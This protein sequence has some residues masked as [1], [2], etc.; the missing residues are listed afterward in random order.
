MRVVSANH[1]FSN[2]LRILRVGAL[3]VRHSIDKM[4]SMK[5]SYYHYSGLHV[6]SELPLPEWSAFESSVVPTAP[7]DVFNSVRRP[8]RSAARAGGQ[9]AL[10][11]RQRISLLRSPNKFLSR[12]RG[13]RNSCPASAESGR[14]E[15]AVKNNRP[16]ESGFVWVLFVYFRVISWISFWVGEE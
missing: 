3:K 4:S 14:A 2:G 7:A 11:E 10:R 5:L 12:S 15:E 9:V 16:V 1:H 13:A 8:T 6:A